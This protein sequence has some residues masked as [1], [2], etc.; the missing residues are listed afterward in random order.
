MQVV[1][2]WQRV[3]LPLNAINLSWSLGRQGTLTDAVYTGETQYMNVR[4]SV[5][6]QQIFCVQHVLE[7]DPSQTTK[8]RV[9]NTLLKL[10]CHKCSIAKCIPWL[11]FC[12]WQNSFMFTLNIIKFT[13][14]FCLLTKCKKKAYANG[15]A[16]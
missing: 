7:T 14:T 4:G 3:L 6:W 13:D 9:F 16:S 12:R 15:C 8:S 1:L 10:T 5:Y 2:M 11:K